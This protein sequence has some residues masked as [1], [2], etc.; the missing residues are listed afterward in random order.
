MILPVHLA[1]AAPDLSLADPWAVIAWRPPCKGFKFTN[2]SI[3][4]AYLFNFSNIQKWLYNIS[5]IRNVQNI[6]FVG[7]ASLWGP[8]S[9]CPM[10]PYV[11]SLLCVWQGSSS[12][13]ISKFLSRHLSKLMH[14]PS[15]FELV[16]GFKTFKNMM[17]VKLS[18]CLW[19][20]VCKLGHIWEQ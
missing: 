4:I 2:Y 11:N 17:C 13:N 8:S 9:T 3:S 15:T 1:F 7:S 20:S 5:D 12:S 10:C 19:S 14:G 16:L 18:C 6:H